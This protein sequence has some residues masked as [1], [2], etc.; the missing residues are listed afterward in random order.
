VAKAPA[1]LAVAGA[2]LRPH[3]AAVLDVAA[4]YEYH[5]LEWLQRQIG[6]ASAGWR[7][8]AAAQLP[9]VRVR[10]KWPSLVLCA[11]MLPLCSF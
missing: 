3:A 7:R 11:L 6:R 5:T 9:V 8:A 10:V 1:V 2:D 4:S